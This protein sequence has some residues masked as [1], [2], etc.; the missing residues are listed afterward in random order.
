M[1]VKTITEEFEAIY[2]TT[3]EMGYPDM[4]EITSF[5]HG[6]GLLA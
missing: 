5:M 3:M 2:G 4:G 6:Y 1:Q